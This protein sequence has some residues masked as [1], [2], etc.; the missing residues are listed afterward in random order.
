MSQQLLTVHPHPRASVGLETKES[1]SATG[2]VQRTQRGKATGH[3][4][5]CLLLL[6]RG[7]PLPLSFP[8]QKRMSPKKR[9]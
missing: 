9:R 3:W 2:Q 8:L 6:P 4:G 1:V 5:L 7:T